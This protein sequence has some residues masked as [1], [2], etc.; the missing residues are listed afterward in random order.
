MPARNI[1]QYYKGCD[2]VQFKSFDEVRIC[3][4][5]KRFE[6]L[7]DLA[8]NM[9]PIYGM[10]ANMLDDQSYAR[11]IIRSNQEFENAG[12][13]YK[14]VDVADSI[15]NKSRLK[16]IYM[17]P[18]TEMDGSIRFLIEQSNVLAARGHSVLL[19][20]HTPEPQWIK[21]NVPFFV[22][23]PDCR[24]SDIISAADIVIAGQWHLAVDALRVKA[25][26]KYHFVQ[27]DFDT[28]KYDN[29]KNF[30]KNAINTAFSLP[31]KILTGSSAM[32]ERIKQLFGREAVVIPCPAECE[33]LH[34]N[35]GI[36]VVAM[37]ETSSDQ[38]K[39]KRE[40][41]NKISRIRSLYLLEKE[42]KTSAQST[43]QAVR[44]K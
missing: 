39:N 43:I 26:L 36:P 3:H 29:L 11:E 14:L 21:C 41:V 13:K 7:N 37:P 23:H 31:L 15:I 20:S 42:F 35:D 2:F 30:E 33:A 40:T 44:I 8:V 17:L 12:R 5:Q 25:P 19:Y 34:E 24:L 32:K 28:S 1:M 18:H 6:F 16:I 10:N 27:E 38:M 22:S 9:D 4:E